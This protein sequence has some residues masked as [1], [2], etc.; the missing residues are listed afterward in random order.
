MFIPRMILL[1]TG[2]DGA[3][4]PQARPVLARIRP[5]CSF[6][7]VARTKLAGCWNRTCAD[8][9]QSKDVQACHCKELEQ[10]TKT[11]SQQ[12]RLEAYR[13]RKMLKLATARNSNKQLRHNHSNNDESD[14]G[15]H[16]FYSVVVYLTSASN[17]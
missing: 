11:Q 7:V 3:V 10:A 2:P 15:I 16:T 13:C 4:L 1:S 6:A 9:G 12:Q 8:T 17:V 14:T 5:S